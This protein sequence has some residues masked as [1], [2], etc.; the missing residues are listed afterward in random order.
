MLITSMALCPLFRGP[1]GR[2]R[3]IG[4]SRLRHPA[5]RGPA[6]PPVTC[7]RSTHAD[8]KIVRAAPVAPVAQPLGPPDFRPHTPFTP[9]KTCPTPAQSPSHGSRRRAGPAP[10]PTPSRPARLSLAPAL[11]S[12]PPTGLVGHQGPRSCSAA[13][14]PLPVVG[15]WPRQ[16]L[17]GRPPA[18]SLAWGFALC[19]PTCP[20][21]W[22]VAGGCQVLSSRWLACV[23][24]WALPRGQRS[25]ARL[26]RWPGASPCS[27]GGLRPLACVGGWAWPRARRS[28]G[29][30]ARLAGEL[31]GGRTGAASGWLRGLASCR[32]FGHWWFGW[33]GL[34]EGAGLDFAYG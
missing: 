5:A 18:V 26:R 12:R 6:E 7:G 32:H 4:R 3:P 8:R 29:W 15:G 22:S 9:C 10:Q 16:A 24:G 23:G 11:G 34:G 20:P 31:A 17:S 21:G 27:A 25:S 1:C 19:P 30:R 2:F 33:R 28:V 14:R 13:A